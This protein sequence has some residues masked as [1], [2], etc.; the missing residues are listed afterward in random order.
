MLKVGSIVT[1]ADSKD[2]FE[3]VEVNGSYAIV[4]QNT[5]ENEFGYTFKSLERMERI[6][7]FASI[8]DTVLRIGVPIIDVDGNKD[9]FDVSV[10]FAKNFKESVEYCE[11]NL[12]EYYSVD[13]D[14][15]SEFNNVNNVGEYY[16]DVIEEDEVY[17]IFNT[18]TSHC[19][20]TFMSE[21]SAE[22]YL[23]EY[24]KYGVATT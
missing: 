13:Y 4:N 5:G 2:K 9:I 18:E 8:D 16:V 7:R 1:F 12:N 19:Y 17:G 20:G 14:A 11:K 6:I 10:Y 24:F 23:N 21:S 22:E 3:I 15:I